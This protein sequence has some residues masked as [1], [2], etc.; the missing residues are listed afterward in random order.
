MYR[1][2]G[3]AQPGASHH[4]F[5]KNWE[6]PASWWGRESEVQGNQQRI[7]LWRKAGTRNDDLGQQAY[8][9]SSDTSRP[10]R[11]NQPTVKRIRAR[12]K[13]AEGMRDRSSVRSSVTGPWVAAYGPCWTGKKKMLNTQSVASRTRAAIRARR[14]ARRRQTQEIAI[15]SSTTR[16]F[17]YSGQLYIAIR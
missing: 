16:S 8:R 13:L 10:D 5:F 12:N 4:I 14:P 11:M 2:S 17:R 7:T 3:E 15:R 6:C 9:F 1:T